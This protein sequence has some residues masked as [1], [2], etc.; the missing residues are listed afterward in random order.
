MKRGA[1]QI[2]RKIFDSELWLEKPAS[3]KVI[4][5]YILGKVNHKES[6]RFKRGEGFINFTYSRREI[7]IDITPDII[8]KSLS[9]FRKSGMI[10]TKRSTRGLIIKVL[11]YNEYQTLDNYTSTKVSTTQAREK[12]E[13]STPINKNVK[14][15]KNIVFKKTKTTINPKIIEDIEK[16]V[17]SKKM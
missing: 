15:E 7:G 13:R 8:K 1:F 2:A 11:K 17:R 12:H 16:I 4:W 5:I 6:G 9:F 14:N 3:W 10:D